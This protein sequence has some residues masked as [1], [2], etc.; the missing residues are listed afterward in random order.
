[1]DQDSVLFVCTDSGTIKF[2]DLTDLLVK[3]GYF[4]SYNV[5]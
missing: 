3:Q 2:A 4:A 5:A 1:M